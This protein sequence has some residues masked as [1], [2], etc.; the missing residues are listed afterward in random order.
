MHWILALLVRSKCE[1]DLSGLI[2]GGNICIHFYTILESLAAVLSYLEYLIVTN[3]KTMAIGGKPLMI[4]SVFV[5]C[6]SHTHSMKPLYK[7]VLYECN[8]WLSAFHNEIVYYVD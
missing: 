4:A 1:F 2:A 3:E 8:V 6:R 5:N 7:K